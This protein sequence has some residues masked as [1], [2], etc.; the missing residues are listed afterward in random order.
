MSEDDPNSERCPVCKHKECQDHLLARFDASGDEGE[1]GVGLT[2]GPLYYVNEIEEVLQRARLSWVQSVRATGKCK[3]PRWIMKERGLQDY[4]DALGGLG[5]FD[6][7]EYDSDEDAADDLRQYTD[8]E[9]VRARFLDEVLFSCG[10]RGEKTEE[11]YDIPLRST[12]YLCWWAFKP[13]EIVKGS[14]RNSEG[15]CW[16][17]PTQ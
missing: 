16:M 1:L 11:E 4:V 10:W 7:E 17:P 5:G 6:L 9:H 3:A 8:T 12:T 15:S 13:S 14:G 2:A